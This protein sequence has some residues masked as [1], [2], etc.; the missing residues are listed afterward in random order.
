MPRAVSKDIWVALFKVRG[1]CI[2]TLAIRSPTFPPSKNSVM[3][4]HGCALVHA[5]RNCTMLGCAR[6]QRMLSSARKRVSAVLLVNSSRW[7]LL[8][9]T[10]VPLHLMRYTAPNDPSPSMLSG[11]FLLAS[12][13]WSTPTFFP[14]L[15]P[16]QSS[17]SSLGSVSQLTEDTSRSTSASAKV[18]NA[19]PLRI[20]APC[21]L[22][23]STVLMWLFLKASCSGVP[24]HR[25]TGLGL[26]PC[27]SSHCTVSTR[28]S[29]AA[30]CRVVLSS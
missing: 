20:L 14:F 4:K 5:P 23:A 22:S 16:L 2:E 24:P 10:V 25:S 27:S 12:S 17:S 18:T 8:T 19:P 29:E 6:E 15:A 30:K 13:S 9:A 21:L 26:A 7:S 11:Y 1:P 3:M 28:P